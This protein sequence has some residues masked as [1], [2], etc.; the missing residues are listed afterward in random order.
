MPIDDL[1]GET[2]V[3]QRA[4][5]RALNA[6]LEDPEAESVFPGRPPR[7]EQRVR[8]LADSEDEAEFPPLPDVAKRLPRYAGA[9]PAMLA[10][11]L[12]VLRAVRDARAG[13]KV[14]ACS[15]L[16]VVDVPGP[17]WLETVARQWQA[18]F[19]EDSEPNDGDADARR[20]R[21]AT[22]TSFR[23]DGTDAAHVPAKGNDIVAKAIRDGSAVVGFSAAPDGQL[24][25]HLTRSPTCRIVIPAL[26]AAMLRAV[27]RE[28]TGRAPT[29]YIAD[30]L[31]GAVTPDLLRLARRPRQSAN[32]FLAQLADFAGAVAI[33]AVGRPGPS[34]DGIHGMDEAVAWGRRWIV[35]LADY[36][37]GKID[38]R[39]MDA[40]ALLHGPP[41]T[42]KTMFAE[43]LAR[44]AGIP[45]IATS[46][47]A[48]QASGN[49]YLGDCVRAM[50][51][52]F[53]EARR[54][55]PCVL[56]VDEFDAIGSRVGQKG[57]HREY[58]TTIVTC[59]LEMLDG[60]GGRAG[61]LVLGTTNDLGALDPALLRSGRLDRLIQVLPPDVTALAGIL[62]HHLGDDLPGADIAA[63]AR[64][65]CGGTGAD[66]ARWVRSAR[67]AARQARRAV[68]TDDLLDA[69][70]IA[71]LDPDLER[72]IAVHEAGHAVA[73]AVLRPGGIVDA[74]IGSATAP[75]GMVQIR[76]D[77]R[78]TR[79]A[80]HGT[81]VELLAGRAA[82]EV[83]LGD[84]SGG[85][86]GSGGSDLAAATCFAVSLETALGLG[87]CGP[88]WQALPT[89]DTVGEML[90]ARPAL[91]RRVQA[92]LEEI[93]SAA[94]A[95]VR[96]HSFA[97]SAVADALIAA[98]YLTGAEVAALVARHPPETMPEGREP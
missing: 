63:A 68:A 20:Q 11:R 52:S 40:A 41:G 49:G 7:A 5:A 48:W 87:A 33:A 90:V 96:K 23:R 17:A 28:I 10:A 72:R 95:L 2:V 64:L 4:P 78:S 61:V 34:L 54:R 16:T 46:F 84:Y 79:G 57:E 22:W 31:P 13:T 15:G 53:D 19:R 30:G 58:W 67:Q 65:A 45:L 56:L 29:A 43:A 73:I 21:R 91:A 82:E 42:G 62:R 39:D 50:R 89:P 14:R 85:S 9:D 59:A 77:T 92:H 74:R 66:C 8:Y 18:Q 38:W 88:V 83:I 6:E 26:D 37:N 81:L 60:V 51:A 44:T 3:G 75:T 71:A 32:A 76:H 27:I 93:H 36:R 69:I 35:D 70:G 94:A 1:D 80:V 55:A 86:G 47:S 97:V 98:R 24:P 12:M 25:M